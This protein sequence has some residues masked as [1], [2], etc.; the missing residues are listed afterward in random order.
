MINKAIIPVAGLGTRFLPATIAQPKE[1]L[2]LVDKPAIQF[3]VEEAHASGIEDIIL[4]TGKNKR[5][6]EDHFGPSPDLIDLLGTK[7]KHDII[8]QVNSVAEMGNLFYVRQNKPLGLGH[9]ILQAERHIGG[10][11]FAVMLGDAII[12]QKTPCMLEMIEIFNKYKKPVIAV[13]QV[14]KREISNY[15]I[16]KITKSISSDLFELSDIIEKPKPNVAPSNWAVSARYI[17]TPKIFN[18]LKKAQ[19]TVNGEIQLT[20]SLAN[21]IQREGGAIAYAIK[22]ERL[23][24]GSKLEYAKAFVKLGLRNKEI[25]VEFKRY[26]QSFNKH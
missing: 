18:Y 5:A 10:E 11:N 6:I 9:A 19:P 17:L 14:E 25:G 7:N 3:V 1:M 15:G 4:I 26:I 23:D 22:G 24:V 8:K 16:V 21:Y 12:D 13:E 2:P 20:D